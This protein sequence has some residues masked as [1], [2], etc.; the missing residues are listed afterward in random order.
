M[1]HTAI[2][3]KIKRLRKERGYSHEKMAELLNMSSSAYQRHESDHTKLDL[4]WLQA[5]ARVLEVDLIDLLRGSPIVV[6]MRD[7]TGGACGHNNVVHQNS[8]LTEVIRTID[9]NHA[10]QLR[11]HREFNAK[12]MTVLDRMLALVERSMDSPIRA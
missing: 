6:N 4:D 11:E 2:L 12:V 3:E 7:H 1:D 10:E 8:E 9:Q 5:V